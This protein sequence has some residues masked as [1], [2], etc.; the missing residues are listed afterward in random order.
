[1]CEWSCP[2]TPFLC[3]VLFDPIFS[4]LTNKLATVTLSYLGFR[5]SFFFFSSFTPKVWQINGRTSSVLVVWTAFFFKQGRQIS[6]KH[7]IGVQM[8]ELRPSDWE[9]RAYDSHHFDVI[10]KPLSDPL[11]PVWNK[12]SIFS[13]QAWSARHLNMCAAS[14][15]WNCKC[16]CHVVGT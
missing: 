4:S 12:F 2:V 7:P 3:I 8:G 5:K 11:R 13:P 10:I 15:V 6:P 9:G 14:S 1:M 16:V